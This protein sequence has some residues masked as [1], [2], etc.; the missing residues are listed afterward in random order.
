MFLLEITR[1]S[2]SADGNST[3][4]KFKLYDNTNKIVQEGYTL[5]PGGPDTVQA[6]LDKRIPE[7]LYNVEWYKSPKYKDTLANLYNDKVSINRRILIH[8][9]NYGKDT[10]GC[11]LLGN[12]TNGKDMVTESSKA[13]SEF[14]K[15]TKQSLPLQVKIINGF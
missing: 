14:H 3:L 12:G 1:I 4:G 7:G 13:I 6:N 10:L 5:E 8:V 9:G 11:I 15:I 2:N